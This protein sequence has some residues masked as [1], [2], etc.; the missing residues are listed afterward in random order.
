MK[1]CV[2]LGFLYDNRVS[3]FEEAFTIARSLLRE[4]KIDFHGTYYDVDTCVLHPRW[5]RPGGP[6]LMIGSIGERM[7]SITL[8]SIEWLGDVLTE[9]RKP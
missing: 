2:Q 7:L 9:F 5:P 8:D 1:I 3:R 6:P 4:G